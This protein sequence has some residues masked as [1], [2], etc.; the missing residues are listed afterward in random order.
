LALAV[1]NASELSGQAV[2]LAQ[3]LIEFSALLVMGDRFFIFPP[4]L[5]DSSQLIV[6]YGNSGSIVELLTQG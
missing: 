6:G 2:S 4:I 5:I 3:L 1:G